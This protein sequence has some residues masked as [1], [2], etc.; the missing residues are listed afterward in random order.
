MKKVLM[1]AAS[2]SLLAG[3]AAGGTPQSCLDALDAAE[4]V[5]GWS[6]QAMGVMVDALDD[7]S[8]MGEY[9]TR[10]E[11]INVELNNSP[12]PLLAA[13]CRSGQ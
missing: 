1:V 2:A 8:R 5:M 10:L 12:Y 11:K 4:D 7:P 3:C 9:A 6:G 13:Q